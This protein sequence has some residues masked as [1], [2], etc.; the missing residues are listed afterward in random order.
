MFK[1]C[2]GS[3]KIHRYIYIT[4][5]G[6]ARRFFFRSPLNLSIVAIVTNAASIV[7]VQ[8]TV[9][10]TNGLCINRDARNEDDR[11]TTEIHPV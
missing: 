7:S 1:Y 8:E 9:F 10:R 2:T 11:R 5:G 4:N 3:N 6:R